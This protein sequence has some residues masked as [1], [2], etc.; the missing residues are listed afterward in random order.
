[1]KISKSILKQ[2]IKEELENLEIDDSEFDS[3]SDAKLVDMAWKDGIEEFIVLDAE[4][5][6]VN[7]EEVLAA[8]K[9]A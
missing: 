2:I 7:R 6:L 9:N 5:D 1:M 4:G 3:M 8:L